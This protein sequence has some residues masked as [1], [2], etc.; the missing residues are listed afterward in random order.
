[1]A[2]DYTNNLA[3][4][5]KPW[6]PID[7][8]PT[9]LGPNPF[10]NQRARRVRDTL[11]VDQNARALALRTVLVVN[12]TLNRAVW[13]LFSSQLRSCWP[14]GPNQKCGG[15]QTPRLAHAAA[16]LSS[17]WDVSLPLPSGTS[18]QRKHHDCRRSR[19]RDDQLSSRL[20]LRQRICFSGILGQVPPSMDSA[21]DLMK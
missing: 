13:V 19:S 18:K 12:S 15:N 20:R 17:I 2:S 6:P 14:Y 3:P 8:G 4:S 11:A 16:R 9:C 10:C 21:I 5:N 7:V 1:M